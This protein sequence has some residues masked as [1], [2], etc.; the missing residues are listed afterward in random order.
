LRLCWH[1][2]LP[3]PASEASPARARADAGWQAGLEEQGSD[4][5]GASV[6]AGEGQTGLLELPLDVRELEKGWRWATW[7]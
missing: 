3:R 2:R 5:G 6:G 1:S 7:G 4:E